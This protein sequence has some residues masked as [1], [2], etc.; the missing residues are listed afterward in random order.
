MHE[1]QLLLLE[2]L[3][4]GLTLPELVVGP[5]E[6]ESVAK[7]VVSQSVVIELCQLEPLLN[8]LCS[9]SQTEMSH[10]LQ[11]VWTSEPA[12]LF[13]RQLLLLTRS[14]LRVD[15][16]PTPLPTLDDCILGGYLHSRPPEDLGRRKPGRGIVL[17]GAK[18][19]KN[20]QGLHGLRVLVPEQDLLSL[21]PREKGEC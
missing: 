6:L 15:E 9:L 13:E 16:E 8:H 20:D 5:L 21:G 18:P 11:G 1:L 19:E 3:V 4:L 17:E 2:V 14:L 7:I 12:D 10:L